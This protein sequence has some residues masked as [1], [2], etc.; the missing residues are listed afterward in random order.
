[1]KKI[2]VILY[3]LILSSCKDARRRFYPHFYV[4]DYENMQIINRD[5]EAVKCEEERFNEFGCMHVDKINELRR[6]LKRRCR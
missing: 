2:L 1:M 6:Y 5:H 4:G 3:L